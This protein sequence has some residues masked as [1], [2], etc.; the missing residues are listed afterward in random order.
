MKRASVRRKETLHCDIRSTACGSGA[1]WCEVVDADK[2]PE[3]ESFAEALDR[4]E[5]LAVVAKKEFPERMRKSRSGYRKCKLETELGMGS[6]MK[7]LFGDMEESLND[8]L[9]K[10]EESDNGAEV[11]SKDLGTE[12][13][14]SKVHGE[15]TD[16]K[17]APRC[18]VVALRNT[19]QRTA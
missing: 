2:C 1:S 15:E 5:G 3:A 4:T 6:F 16:N 17:N 10:V 9:E 11:K 12:K 19:T 7:D 14:K 8:A 13:N 18:L